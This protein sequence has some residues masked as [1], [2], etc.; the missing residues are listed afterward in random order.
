MGLCYFQIQVSELL[1]VNAPIVVFVEQPE[2]LLKLLLAT[3]SVANKRREF[4][5]A[6]KSIVVFICSFKN[7]VLVFA[8]LFFVNFFIAVDV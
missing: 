6:E 8:K 2:D 5:K 1:A 7:L 4:L 3:S